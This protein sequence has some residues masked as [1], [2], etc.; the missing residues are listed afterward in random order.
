MAINRQE[1]KNSDCKMNL[2]LSYFCGL[3]AEKAARTRIFPFAD[4][5]SVF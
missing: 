5:F 1:L 3:G 2:F 4:G